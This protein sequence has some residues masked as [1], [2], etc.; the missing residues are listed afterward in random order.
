[1]LVLPAKYLPEIRY[2]PHTKISLLDAQFNASMLVSLVQYGLMC[3]QSVCGN[4]TNILNDSN[5][6]AHTVAKKLTPSLRM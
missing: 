4:Y 1:M 6:P 2:L 5:L 3:L